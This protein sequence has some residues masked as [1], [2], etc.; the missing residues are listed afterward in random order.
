MN[1]KSIVAM[2]S[3]RC[4]W[5][6]HQKNLTEVREEKFGSATLITKVHECPLCGCKWNDLTVVNPTYQIDFHEV[7]EKGGES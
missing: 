6:A 4:T 1:I 3:K 5:L 2:L 7:Q